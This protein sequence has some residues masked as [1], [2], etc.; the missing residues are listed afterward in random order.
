MQSTP[1]SLYQQSIDKQRV[2]VAGQSR[3][4]I[5]EMVL[6][7]LKENGRKIDLSTSV[8]EQ[9][10][11][12]PTIIVEANGSPLSMKDFQPHILIL[13]RLSADEK[14][15]YMNLADAAPKSGGIFFNDSDAIAKQVATKE[16]PDVTV[17]PYSLPK[18]E[19]TNK[20]AILISSTNE[21]FQTQLMTE[22]DLKDCA[23]AKEFLKKIGISSSQFYRTIT[24]FN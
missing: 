6:F 18:H 7:V 4:R 13:S 12:S 11:G 3:A 23:A 10:L 20:G 17:I 8:S 22:D 14:E 2:V 15:A 19:M 16:R 24:R 1:S 5:I 21:K 9:I